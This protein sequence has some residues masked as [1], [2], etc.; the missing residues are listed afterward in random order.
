MVGWI[1]IATGGHRRWAA[2]SALAARAA[3]GARSAPSTAPAAARPR[4]PPAIERREPQGPGHR[5]RARCRFVAVLVANLGPRPARDRARR[6]SGR[7]RPLSRCGRWA[8]GAPVASRAC[9]ASPW[10]ST[11]GRPGA[12]PASRSTRCSWRGPRARA[13]R[14]VPRRRLRGQ[15]GRRAAPSWRSRAAPIRRCST[16]TAAPRSRT[17]SPACPRHIS[18]TPQGTIVEKYVGPLDEAT[19]LA[20]SSKARPER[21]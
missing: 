9:G 7:P 21:R 11:S 10:S 12:C 14:A 19:L 6:W 4:R 3:A 16:T 1:W 8:A 2:W 5:R 15:R 20:S 13:R 18:S 17:A